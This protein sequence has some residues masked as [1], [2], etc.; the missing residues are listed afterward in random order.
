MPLQSPEPAD[1]GR[2]VNSSLEQNLP[3]ISS[4]LG[5]EIARDNVR[6][7]IGG[8][9]PLLDLVAGRS[10]TPTDANENLVGLQ[11]FPDVASKFNDRQ[12]GP[13]PTVPI[14]TG[15]VGPCGGGRTPSPLVAP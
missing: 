6:V 4:R 15:G 1:E 5:A 2:W 9:P 12:I 8:H 13:Q 3:L 14:F 7:A 10:Y 11:D